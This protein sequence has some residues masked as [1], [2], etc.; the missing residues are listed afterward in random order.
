MQIS[1]DGAAQVPLLTSAT[2]IFKDNN[3]IVVDEAN[4]K[5]YWLSDFNLYSANMD[6]LEM[7]TLNTTLLTGAHSLQLDAEE[8]RL[9]WMEGTNLRSLPLGTTGEPQ[10][11]LNQVG[12]FQLYHSNE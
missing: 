10:T 6:G 1:P 2:E 3:G 7:T 11:L 9:L 12:V 5:L 8:G 4:S